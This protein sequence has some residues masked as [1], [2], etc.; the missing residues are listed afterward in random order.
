MPGALR[1]L[2]R[3]RVTSSSQDEQVLDEVRMADIAGLPLGP[4]RLLELLAVAGGPVPT[5]VAIVAANLGDQAVN[6]VSTL[7]AHRVADVS[8]AGADALEVGSRTVMDHVLDTTPESVRQHHHRAL[9]EALE[10]SGAADPLVLATHFAGG[11]DGQRAGTIAW[12]AANRALEA[13]QWGHAVPLLDVALE[14]GAWPARERVGIMATLAR[15]HGLLGQHADAADVL[16]RALERAPEASQSALQR[17]QADAWLSMGDQARGEPLIAYLRDAAELPGFA[18]SGGLLGGG[19]AAWRRFQQRRRGDAFD[20]KLR[21]DVDPEVLHKVDVAFSCV[22]ALG[23]NDPGKAWAYQPTHLTT[24][25]DVGEVERVMRAWCEEVVLNVAREVGADTALL[26]RVEEL[27]AKHR[28]GVAEGYL[29]SARARVAWLRGDVAATVETGGQAVQRMRRTARPDGLREPVRTAVLHARVVSGELER[30]T[31]DVDAL[32]RRGRHHRDPRSLLHLLGRVGTY[33]AAAKRRGPGL[34]QALTKPLDAIQG[35]LPGGW[36]VL[37]LAH[38][39]L[40]EGQP[41]AALQRLASVEERVQSAF[42]DPWLRT[43]WARARGLA[44]RGAGDGRDAARQVA[45]LRKDDRPWAAAWADL[46][47]QRYDRAGGTL[48]GLGWFLEQAAAVAH[49]DGGTTG[50]SAQWLRSKGVED[51]DGLMRTF[52]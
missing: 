52:T 19:M 17:Q 23:L 46:V 18:P 4:R 48:Q 12:L 39:D 42:V 51:V 35:P 47:E 34:R 3:Q 45:L 31:Q 44:A 32:A 49:T 36:G 13:G 29:L 14:H 10:R 22:H 2:V 7:R 37:G 41:G 50:P 30:G 24:A 8:G 15:T 27:V 25:L 1:E 28:S 20:V 21:T 38:M 5:E 6:A 16:A 11:G 43:S 26:E 40:R 9:A 33:V